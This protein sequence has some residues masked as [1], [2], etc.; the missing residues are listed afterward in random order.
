MREEIDSVIGKSRLP[1]M[2]DRA[3]L[4]YID[5]VSKEAFRWNTVT[6][7]W[8]AHV[9]TDSIVYD[10]YLLPKGAVVIPHQDAMQHD[11]RDYLDPF[12]F[13]PSRY[14]PASSG[15][16]A[17]RDPHAIGFG[18]GR[19]RCAGIRVADASVFINCA[20]I[21]TTLDIQK[22]FADGVVVEPLYQKLPGLI[23]Q[24]KPFTVAIKPRSL[25]ALELL[26]HGEEVC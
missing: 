3:A 10:N 4:P 12:K 1:T 19:R 15:R 22:A 20:M 11:S 2:E 17:E 18:F 21:A 7:V 26:K 24:P 8:G 14:L 6:P 9:L 16:P 23:S 13:D 25:A 5:A